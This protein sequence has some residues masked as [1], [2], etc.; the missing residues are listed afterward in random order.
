MI[1]QSLHTAVQDRTNIAA[2]EAM[3]YAEFLDGMGFNSAGLGYV[4]AMANQLGEMYDL[5]Y[6]CL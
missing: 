2:R 5:P 1:S 6:C 4:H 3:A